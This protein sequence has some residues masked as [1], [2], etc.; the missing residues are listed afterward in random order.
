MGGE[1]Y[2]N[3]K[4]GSGTTLALL[5]PLLL[6]QPFDTHEIFPIMVY[7]FKKCFK[8]QN[9][10]IWDKISPLSVQQAETDL[11]KSLF[12]NNNEEANH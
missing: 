11:G 10:P 9:S 5:F 4:V 6:E 2:A 7:I 3:S 1:I 12:K 8:L